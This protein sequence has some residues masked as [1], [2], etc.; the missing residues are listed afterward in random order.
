MGAGP[1]RRS[2]RQSRSGN[3]AQR[4]EY[5][6]QHGVL[7]QVRPDVAKTKEGNELRMRDLTRGPLRPFEEV[8]VCGADEEQARELP[9]LKGYGNVA[10]V[11]HRRR[12]GF[13]R[14]RVA[15]QPECS[16][17]SGSGEPAYSDAY[18]RRLQ[19][20]A[21]PRLREA[22]SDEAPKVG[23][24]HPVRLLA[25]DHQRPHSLW[26]MLADPE[27]QPPRTTC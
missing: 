9:R 7:V 1:D 25:T 11:Q 23:A 20:A 15:I 8:D 26:G 2:R 21:R 16:L 13:D 3:R 5:G 14:G 12:R 27:A 18:T 24:D 10:L 19:G 4:S 17:V 6:S 22:F